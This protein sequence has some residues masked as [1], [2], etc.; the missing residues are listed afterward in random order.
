M[1]G[2]IPIRRSS[3]EIISSCCLFY[4][5]YSCVVH[6]GSA[7]S[8]HQSINDLVHKNGAGKHSEDN[9]SIS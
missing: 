9:V 4:M 6:C 3:V 2:G 7:P 8:S 1:G 5:N